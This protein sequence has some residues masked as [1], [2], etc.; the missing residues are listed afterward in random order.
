MRAVRAVTLR[1]G[2]DG[3]EAVVRVSEVVG[4]DTG[5]GCTVWPSSLVLSSHLWRRRH[6]LRGLRVLELGAGAGLAGLAAAAAGCEVTLSDADDAAVLSNCR[7]SV[8]ANSNSAS[9]SSSSSTP[10]AG[11]LPH[12]SG[13]PAPVRVV[14]LTWGRFRE[15]DLELGPFDV[16]LAADCFYDNKSVYEDFVATVCWLLARGPAESYC[17]V[18][19]QERSA[20]RT[21]AQLLEDWDVDVQC[22]PP[23][24]DV[25]A[26]P[27]GAAEVCSSV[28]ILRLSL[29]RSWPGRL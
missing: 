6:S 12:P 26:L 17:L 15:R 13:S 9:S 3:S 28:H 14:P 19:Y 25:S 22:L 20:S 2:A 1:D 7:A 27:E 21:V 4:S 11:W 18:A 16:L 5:L 23:D 10:R 29:G 8:D 24:D